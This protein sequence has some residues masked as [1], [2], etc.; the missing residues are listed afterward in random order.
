MKYNATLKTAPSMQ[1]EAISPEK[2][3]FC[4]KIVFLQ[5]NRKPK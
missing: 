4:R 1:K 5:N 3:T 2:W